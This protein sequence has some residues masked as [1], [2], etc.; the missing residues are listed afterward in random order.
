MPEP[1]SEEVVRVLV[2]SH[3]RFLAFLTPRVGGAAAAEEILQA[4]FVKGVER[5]G[6]LRDAESAV[7]WF[8]RLLR[9]AVV[10]HYRHQDAERRALE[11]EALEAPATTELESALE[12]QIC[13]CMKDLLPTLKPEYADVLRRVDLDGTPVA[14]VALA[15]GTSSNN[16]SVRLHR[17]RQALKRQLEL[18]CG[19]CTEHG[20]LDCSCKHR[21]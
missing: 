6:D 15:L 13:G 21:P 10:D 1:M 9:N 18:T 14:E 3:A 7:A 4:A 12:A 11:R 8:F 20:C 5:G 2:A 16:T 17:A 19:T